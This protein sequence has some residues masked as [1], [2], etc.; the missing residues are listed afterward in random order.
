M[1]DYAKL[2]G[3][4]KEAGYRQE[5]VG[6]C[7]G[8]TPTTYSLKINNKGEFKQKEI[9]AICRLLQIPADEIPSY[10]FNKRV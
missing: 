2:K 8:L 1:Y 3:R 5:E 6:A 4:T 7:A 9:E 10:F